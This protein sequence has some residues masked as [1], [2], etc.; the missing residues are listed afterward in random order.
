MK[1]KSS[2]LAIIIPSANPENIKICID[3]INRQTKKPGQTVIIFNKKYSFKKK[4]NFIFSY[5]S[6]SNQVFQRNQGL[7]LI[8]K[9]IQLILQL[10]DKFYLHKKAIE[11]LIKEWN[12]SSNDV[13]GI[14]IK[15][16]FKYE[17]VKK[18]KT[19]K[20]ITLTG[21]DHPG[22]VL[23][24][25]FNN[26]LISNKKFTDVDW[27]Q[28]GLSSWK[29]KLVPN[30]FNRKF[31]LIKWSILED[32]IFSYDV[33]FNKKL[34]LKMSNSLKAFEI[35]KNKKNFNIQELFYRG[36]EYAKMHKIF[37][38]T[39]YKNLS[40]I[41]FFYSYITS[42]FL[43]ILWCSCKINKKIFFYLGRLVGIF[44]NIKNIRVL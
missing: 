30:I 20:Y 10:D 38:Y 35:K 32:L 16:N 42:S 21:S 34:K 2:E 6:K 41:A 12:N 22:K 23:I 31:P 44:A 13:A 36:Y 4:K 37:V 14:G 18:F 3:S 28:G 5:S 19:L 11:N 1:Y 29:L 25:G 39:N 9:K 33:K 7:N 26:K 43:G 17:N 24:S 8:K 15:S 27:L 40:K